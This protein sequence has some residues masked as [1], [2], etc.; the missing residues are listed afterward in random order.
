MAEELGITIRGVEKQVAKLKKDGKL[1][2]LGSARSGMW[3]VLN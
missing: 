2:R 3:E 1:S